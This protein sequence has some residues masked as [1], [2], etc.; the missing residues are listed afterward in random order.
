MI[1]RAFARKGPGR[2]PGL[3]AARVPSR[4]R[5]SGV[6]AGLPRLQLN[7][8]NLADDHNQWLRGLAKAGRWT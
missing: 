1:D 7:A 5:F 4:H 2:L 3:F 6:S 8:R